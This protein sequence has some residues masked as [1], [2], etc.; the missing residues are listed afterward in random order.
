VTT[1]A[2]KQTNTYKT[3]S[4]EKVLRHTMFSH[5]IT[6]TTTSKTIDSKNPINLTRDVE[7]SMFQ[8]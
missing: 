8:T 1:K 2:S 4:N 3:L 7:V 6:H 5:S